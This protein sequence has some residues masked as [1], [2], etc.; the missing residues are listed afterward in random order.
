M[1][2]DML[3]FIIN[4]SSLNTNIMASNQME[5]RG[6]QIR[7]LGVLQDSDTRFV[8]LEIYHILYSASAN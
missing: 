5:R 8:E 3:T 7:A 2:A 1:S 4:I 6:I